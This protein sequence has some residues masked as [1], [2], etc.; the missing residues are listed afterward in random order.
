MS[1]IFAFKDFE[2]DALR[3][4]LR[5][6]G[7]RV[8]VQPKVLRL[9]FHLVAQ[10]ERS[11]SSQELLEVLWPDE[12]VTTASVRRAVAGARRALGETGASESNIRTVR[13]HGY[14][15]MPTVREIH[16]SD[17]PARPEEAPELPPASAARTADSE[18]SSFTHDEVAAWIRLRTSADAPQT[19][20]RELYEQTSGNPLL[21]EHVLQSVM[22]DP[23]EQAWWSRL[24]EAASAGGV[25]AALAR[26][27]TGL[28]DTCLNALRA[29]A[30]IG[31]EF[32][33]AVLANALEISPARA[34]EQLSPALGRDVISATTGSVGRHRF[35]HAL[36]RDALYEQLPAP[37]RALW[38]GRV[39]AALEASGAPQTSLAELAE[40]FVRAAPVHDRGRALVYTR[41]AARAAMQRL[42]HEEAIQYLD[43]ALALAELSAA[44]SHEQLEVLLEKGDALLCAGNTSRARDTLLTA[45][46]LA[47]RLGAATELVRA[48][49]LLGRLS[50][51]G[52]VD[53]EHVAL[54]ESALAVLSDQDD[55][56]ACVQALLA[57]ALIWSREHRS[58]AQRA[59]QVL[60]ATRR[61]GDRALR[62]EALLASLHALSDPDCFSERQEIIAEL[63]RA[64]HEHGDSRALL[65]AAAARVWSSVELGDMV[66]AESSISALETLAE[67]LRDPC[68]RWQGR[69]FR[70]MRAVVAGRLSVAASL[71]RETLA[72]GER[73][74]EPTARRVFCTHYGGVLRAQDRLDEAA[75]L[76][77]DVAL[78]HPAIAGW[79]AVLAVIEAEL[80]HKQQARRVLDRLLERD[81]ESLRSDPFTLGALAPAADLCAMVG[82][83]DHARALYDALLPYADRQGVISIGISTHGP[84][85][86]HL[87]RLALRLHDAR[88]AEAHFTRAVAAADAM[89]SPVFSSASCFG[90]AQVLVAAGGAESRERA[91]ELVTRAF[92]LAQT[93]GLRS[94]A[95]HC[96][97][98]A[99][100]A[101][102]TLRSSEPQS[103]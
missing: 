17:V 74:G 71:A 70:T 91:S 33:L 18:L 35:T 73:L 100:R 89:P 9:L 27:V 83:A 87:G 86:R 93:T 72:L 20:I 90:Y 52:S 47:H 78:R 2:L 61:I 79:Q 3:F 49:S 96:R 53:R 103:A 7:Q 37:E 34:L 76:V 4:E 63:E 102:L 65:A 98:L 81:L 36:L 19:A 51:S 66:S 88:A 77:R 50:P 39:G 38:H 48:A 64:G 67:Q 28:D 29:A 97:A 62:A 101:Q 85:A 84:L 24:S 45:G 43:R 69:V 54:L 11:V 16:T 56:R 5:C 41:R 99:E 57:K 30:V 26:Q 1:S 75:A 60:A 59:W 80:G 25:R 58:R 92:D 12:R 8:S 10:R 94:L 22:L 21:L 55:Q 95:L 46:T 40:H 23:R 32:S 14:Q 13:D 15:F 42:A 68:A 82:D 6:A 44:H 31:R